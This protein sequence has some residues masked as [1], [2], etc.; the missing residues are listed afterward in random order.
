MSKELPPEYD[1]M[2]DSLADELER[3]DPE[4]VKQTSEALKRFFAKR[5][6]CWNCGRYVNKHGV[7]SHG[8][9]AARNM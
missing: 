3:T 9:C 4:W 7:C 1:S 6:H 2:L 8:E 5:E